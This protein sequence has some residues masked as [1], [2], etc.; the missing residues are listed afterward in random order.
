MRLPRF[1]LPTLREG[2]GEL[3]GDEAHH[4][5]SVLRLR[6]GARIELFDGR[7]GRAAATISHVRRGHV[8]VTIEGVAPSGPQPTPHVILA[9]APPK[10]PRQQ[11][12]VEKCTELG[13]AAFQPLRTERSVVKGGDA[14]QQHWQRW[15]LEACRQCGRDHLPEVRAGAECAAVFDER[16]AGGFML[17]ADPSPDAAPPSAWVKDAFGAVEVLVLVGPEG[18]WTH[19]EREAA[20]RAGAAPA[21]LSRQV[22]R[23][24]TAAIAATALLTGGFA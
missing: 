6:I 3:T 9:V 10:G 18:G 2:D 11:V 5:A 17:L 19:E 22:L 4:A 8:A 23:V 7:G 13:A 15:A 21:S 24:E 12:L 20:I 16:R 1:H 14:L